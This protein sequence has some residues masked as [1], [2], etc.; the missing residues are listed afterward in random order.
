MRDKFKICFLLI[1]LYKVVKERDLIIL[2]WNVILY[3]LEEDFM[4]LVRFF[5]V[6]Y[7]WFVGVFMNVILCK[8]FLLFVV[9]KIIILKF[10]LLVMI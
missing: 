8:D 5:L 10:W 3:N 6:F 2:Y 4:D 9:L 7:Y 1:E